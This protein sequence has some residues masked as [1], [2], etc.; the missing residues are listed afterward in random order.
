RLADYLGVSRRRL[1]TGTAVQ[2]QSITGYVVGAVPPFGHVQTLRTVVDTA[3][4]D[5]SILYGGGGE[6]NALLRL[7]PAEL[8]RIVGAETADLAMRET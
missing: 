8:R 5:Q 6:I 4:Y 3:V 2:V 1:K 7:T